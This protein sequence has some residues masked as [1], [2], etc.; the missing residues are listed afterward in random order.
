[1]YRAGGDGNDRNERS[2]LVHAVSQEL[3]PPSQLGKKKKRGKGIRFAKRESRFG[4]VNEGRSK[5]ARS[6]QSS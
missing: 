4:E 3:H 5:P 1:M 2:N 6:L